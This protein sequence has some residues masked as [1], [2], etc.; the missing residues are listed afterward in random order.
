MIAV[1]VV[2]LF[3]AG[4]SWADGGFVGV[5][6]FFVLS[7][8]LVCNVLLTEISDRGGI[9]LVR[10]YARRVRR[11]LPA[12]VVMIV[13]TSAIFIGVAAR[14][15]R[16]DMVNDARAALLYVANWRFIAQ[17]QDYFAAEGAESPF[18]HF[19]SLS[20]EEQY[21]F[22]FPALVLLA[23]RLGRGKLT[24]LLP[25]MLGALTL[26]SLTLQIILSDDVVRA[27]Y[28]TDTRLYQILSGATLAAWLRYRNRAFDGRYGWAGSA[29]IAAIVAFLVLSSSLTASMSVS[30][31]GIAATAA[32]LLI[33]VALEGSRSGIA[34]RALSTEPAV[35][36]G[37][38]SLR[39]ISVALA[40]D[41]GPREN[42]RD[43][44]A[45]DVHC[46]RHNR[47]RACCA[48]LPLDRAADSAAGPP[49]IEFPDGW[50]PPG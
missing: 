11:L 24:V 25:A 40:G 8:F 26:V 21:Y 16:V 29:A 37:D 13:A 7:G 38:I 32:S 15:E 27:Y 12:A 30:M 43:R 17:A 5:D 31:R 47:H 1:Y 33:I 22:I 35:F 18:L 36:L 39:H 41:P 42:R 9:R 48:Q 23:W 19:W 4:V 45:D 28:G 2:V 49:W 3:H 34:A 20:I 6:L 10:F 14:L 46:R 50:W 44:S